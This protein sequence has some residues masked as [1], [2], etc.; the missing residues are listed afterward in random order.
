MVPQMG[1]DRWEVRSVLCESLEMLE[2]G[3]HS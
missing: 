3:A 2:T 1:E